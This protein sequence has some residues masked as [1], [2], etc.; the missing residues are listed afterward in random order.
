M[1]VNKRLVCFDFSKRVAV[2]S[3]SVGIETKGQD[4]LYLCYELTGDISQIYIPVQQRP[5]IADGLWE[6][7]CFELFIAVEDDLAY[8]EFNF[9]PSGQWAIYAFSDYRQRRFFKAQQAPQISF[10]RSNN[11]LRLD[12]TINSTVLP[13]NIADKKLQLGLSA[14]IEDNS[15][16]HTYWALHHPSMV[17]DFHH[18]DGFVG[19][20]SLAAHYFSG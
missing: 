1:K 6:H 8:H 20:Q 10:F 5:A 19:I 9:S 4:D 17:P 12:A 2:R 14:V 16:R 3:L 13:V 18:R 7:T 15:G 11:Y